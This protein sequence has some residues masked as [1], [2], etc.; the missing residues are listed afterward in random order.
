MFDCLFNGTAL[1]G[2]VKQAA[3]YVRLSVCLFPLYLVIRLTFELECFLH[4][5]RL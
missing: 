5:Y 2:K 3:M 1:A 4:A